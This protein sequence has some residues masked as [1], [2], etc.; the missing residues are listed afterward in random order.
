M[1]DQERRNT[2]TDRS[3]RV[4]IVVRADKTGLGS[5]TL[6]LTKMLN[7][8]RVMLIDSTRFKK[9][10]NYGEWYRDYSKVIAR[11][12][13]PPYQIMSFL[14][15]LDVV[16]TCETWY[17]SRFVDIA[18]SMGVKT[19]LIANYEF[20]EH[21]NNDKA[22]LPDMIVSPSYWYLDDMKE[23]FNSVYLPTPIHHSEYKKARDTNLSRSGKT[24]FLF[25][26]G[27]AAV[28]DRNG[29]H[30][31]YEALKH[32]TGDF[33]VT[34]K[35]QHDVYKS[36]DSRIIYDTANPDDSNDL[37]EDFDAMIFPRRYAGQSLPMTEALQSALPVIMTDIS[38]NNQVLPKEWLVPATK[39]GEFMTRFM[40]DL[41]DVDAVALAN[42]MDN[43]VPSVEQKE[44]AYEIGK[45]YDM[46]TLYPQYLELLGL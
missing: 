33:T 24:K 9:M 2:M 42:L 26:N 16:I 40:T 11:S 17:S 25:I 29:L 37:Y 34:I 1:E 3:T 18:H 41:Y 36:D 38:P 45:Q 6:R 19:I 31:L 30:Q 32:S 21:L 39:S 15:T 43:F 44:K 23:R 10:K 5:Q 7:P 22:R 8:E 46:D 12:F 14:K 20:L 4:G 28:H 27:K 13:P 35:A